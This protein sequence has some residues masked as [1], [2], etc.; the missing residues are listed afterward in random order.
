M[1]T[2]GTVECWG[3]DYAGLL[4]APGGHFTAVSA[5]PSH[6]C[7]I[8]T[9]GTIECWGTVKLPPDGVTTVDHGSLPAVVD[10]M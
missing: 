7:A 9:N 5:S 3:L 8:R 4:N 10:N 1:R 2:N 6:S